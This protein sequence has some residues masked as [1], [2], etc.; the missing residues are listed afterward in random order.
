MAL[1][2]LKCNYLIPP[3]L[4]RLKE[5]EVTAFNGGVEILPDSSSVAVLHMRRLKLAK[6][7][8]NALDSVLLL[9]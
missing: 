7:V 3:G 2:T 5:I 1:N 4:K 6:T 9:L 8:V